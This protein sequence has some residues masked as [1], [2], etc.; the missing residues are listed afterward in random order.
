MAT[1]LHIK[2][3]IQKTSWKSLTSSSWKKSELNGRKRKSE[4]Q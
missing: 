2:S 3:N 4:D 1:R